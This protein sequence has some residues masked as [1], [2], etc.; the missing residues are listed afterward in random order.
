MMS[1]EGILKAKY[2]QVDQAMVA[3]DTATLAKLLKPDTVFRPHEGLC[4]TSL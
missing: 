1:D 4:A 3:K 2:R